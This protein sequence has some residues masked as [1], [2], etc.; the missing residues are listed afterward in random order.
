MIRD[1]LVV[2]R[3]PFAGEWEAETDVRRRTQCEARRSWNGTH[4]NQSLRGA[5]SFGRSTSGLE[6]S[7]RR[8][9]RE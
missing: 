6:L 5:I 4:P 3:L 2:V 7:A 9:P 8:A 1:R